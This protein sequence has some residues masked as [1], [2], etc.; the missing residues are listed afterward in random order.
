M[1]QHLFYVS[2]PCKIFSQNFKLL[3]TNPK[4]WVT[5]RLSESVRT[6]DCV[7]RDRY[8]RYILVLQSAL[9][10]LFERRVVS[11]QDFITERKTIK[12]CINVCAVHPSYVLFFSEISCRD[13]IRQSE[14][15]EITPGIRL[16]T[17]Y[18][19]RRQ[20]KFPF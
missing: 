15:N 20:K 8:I 7:Q 11:C 1:N 17:K 9:L 16:Q 4:L 3:L 14:V 18:K 13:A 2:A 5:A 6:A 12:A 10:M 19:N